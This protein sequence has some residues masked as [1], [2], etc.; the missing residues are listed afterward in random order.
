MELFYINKK[1]K[2]IDLSITHHAMM[3]FKERYNRKFPNNKITDLATIEATIEKWWN[4]A[5]PKINKTRKLTTRRK[6][7]GI[8]TLYFISTYFQFVVQ[9]T[10][11]V[12]IEFG[13]RDTRHLNKKPIVIPNYV[14][15]KEQDNE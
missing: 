4:T 5:T 1:D 9:N 7:H 15:E 11:I 8:D 14:G 10:T 12:T 13:S 3:R 6:R 2:R